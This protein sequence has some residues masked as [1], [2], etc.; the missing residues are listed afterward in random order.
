MRGFLWKQM[1]Q[2]HR[3]TARHYMERRSKLDVSIREGG[4]EKLEGIDYSR[5]TW[6]T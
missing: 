4:L 1:G 6:L 3:P 2:V 5:R